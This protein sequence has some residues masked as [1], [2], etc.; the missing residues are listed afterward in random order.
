MS[1]CGRL[2]GGQRV[3][4]GETFSKAGGSLKGGKFS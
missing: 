4:K 2:F 3:P 1:E